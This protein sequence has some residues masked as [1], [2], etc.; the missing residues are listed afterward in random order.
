MSYQ[1]MWEQTPY[2]IWIARYCPIPRT[3]KWSVQGAGKTIQEAES[4][5]WSQYNKLF[6]TQYGS[7]I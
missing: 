6:N 7:R 2:G 3:M 4:A 1:I 5:M